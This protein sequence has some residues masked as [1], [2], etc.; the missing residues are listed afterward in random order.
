MGK[1]VADAV[2]DAA[3]SYIKTNAILLVVCSDTPTTYANATATYD[4]A[5]VAID[6]DDMVIG[7]G[8]VSGRKL[9]I[10][11]QAAVTIDHSGTATHIAL[12]SSDTLL[13]VTT[14]TSQAL[15]A[16]NTVTVPAW[17]IELADPTA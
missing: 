15:T 10:S 9:T 8:T 6:G 2:L 17:K 11:E 14:C 3:L 1:M 13:Y 16:A 12:C 5:D 4:L 7:D